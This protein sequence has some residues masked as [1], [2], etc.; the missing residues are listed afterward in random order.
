[1][2]NL[3]FLRRLRLE[4]KLTLSEVSKQIGIAENYL[5][6]LETGHRRPS[7]EIAKKLGE[8][9]KIAWTKFFE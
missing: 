3:L 2:T 1:M 8:F 9:Y 6:Q 5:S 7:V 4:K